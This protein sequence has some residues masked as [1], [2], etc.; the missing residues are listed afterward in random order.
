M[1]QTDRLSGLVSGAALKVPCITATIANITLS[2]EQ[3]IDGVAVVTGDRV[4]VKSQTDA[5]ENG[6]YAVDTGDWS[7]SKDF[8]GNEDVV[9]GTFVYV[10]DGATTEGYWRVTAEDPIVIDTTSITWE[11]ALVND[12]SDITFIASQAGAVARS[13]QDKERDI[14]SIFDFMTAA[15]IADVK[16]YTASI[17]CT[18]AA[19]AAFACAGKLVFCPAGAYKFASNLTAPTCRGI[20]GEGH[21]P[22]NANSGTLFG[23]S[24]TQGLDIRGTDWEGPTI[25]QDFY[26]GGTSVANA[27]GLLIGNSS[28]AANNYAWTNGEVRNVRITG[29]SG[30][31]SVGMYHRDSN[32]CNFYDVRIDNC[33]M[34]YWASSCADTTAYGNTNTPA[35]CHHYNMQ[36]SSQLGTTNKAVQIASGAQ[37]F[38]DTKI[39][40]CQ[41]IA[42]WI[43]PGATGACPAFGAFDGPVPAASIQV[44][45]SNLAS[46]HVG[47]TGGATS[48]V[49]RV[50]SAT[51]NGSAYVT[52]RDC[53]TDSST[54]LLHATGDT[55]HV[56]IDNQIDYAGAGMT[57]AGTN[58]IRV[59][60]S[61]HLTVSNWGGTNED[62]P[63][64]L[65]CA[66]TATSGEISSPDWTQTYTPTLTGVT[67]ITA[68]TPRLCNFVRVGN[69][70]IV[71][72]TCDIDPTAAAATQL[73]IS[74]PIASNFTNSLQCAGIIATS[75]V[76]SYVGV[77]ISDSTNDRAEFNFVSLDGNNRTFKFQFQYQI[78]P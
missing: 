66:S 27:V 32:F 4:L 44:T 15:Q 20:I 76:A 29:F 26:I 52:I 70:C 17:D 37:N 72:G 28:S 77:V 18:A 47:A 34:W 50:E 12:S 39:N 42:I 64:L 49:F 67:N 68:S 65:S 8:D 38:H 23:F 56:Y 11:Q 2:A 43:A 1:S 46:E 9:K 54:Y 75:E 14:V 48:Q 71:S 35:D 40:T 62:I 33:T 74:L 45:F 24:G 10:T 55:A 3:T 69:Q 36:L 30:T 58:Y 51:A 7:R 25:L 19:N 16:A 5:T 60:A 73:G 41:D 13:V 53:T 61:A 59:I 57:A 31:N 21:E 22:G 6:I 63:A 78:I